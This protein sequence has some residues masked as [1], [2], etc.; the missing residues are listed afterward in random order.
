[1][2]KRKRMAEQIL[3]HGFDLKRVFFSDDPYNPNTI[4]PLALAKAVHR[5][6]VRAH[7][8][9]EQYCNGDI[10]LEQYEKL[11]DGIEAALDRLLGFKAKGIPVLINGDPR[12]YALK[13]ESEYVKDHNI[14]IHRD[15]GG[16]GILAPEFD[17]NN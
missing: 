2:N 8:M 3:R 4:S 15:W 13:I 12:G 1:M 14:D 6:E 16:Y 5:L 9:A 10:E 7:R 17:G 11:T